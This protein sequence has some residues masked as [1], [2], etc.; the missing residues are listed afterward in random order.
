MNTEYIMQMRPWFGEEE[1][2]AICEYMDSDGFLTEF[3]LTEKFEN[4]I[5]SYT[6]SKNCIVVNNGTISMTIA[7]IALDLKA[8]DEVIVPNYTMIATPNA[9]R[10]LG[11]K[12]IF[13]DVD[14]NTLCLDW[15]KVADSLTK[16][17]K[18]VVLVSAN[19]RYPSKD[20]QEIKDFC[21]EKE[22][23][24]IE[25]A[26][27]SLGSFYPNKKHIGTEG[28]I[29]SFSFSAPKIITTGQGGALVTNNDE[30][31]AKIRRLKDF[32]RSSGGNDIHNTIGYNFKFTDL[33][34]CIGIEQMKKLNYRVELKR[35]IKNS[36][37]KHLRGVEGIKLFD[38]DLVNTTPWFI[39]SVC[40]SRDELVKFLHT[41]SIG[42]R[43]MY[44]PINEQIAYSQPGHYPVAKKIG[45][46]GLWLPSSSQL[47]YSDIL[48]VCNAIR[49]FYE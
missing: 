26:A 5:A 24:L 36:Y 27:Q 45:Q 39:D 32:G 38:Q 2:K 47:R 44:P 25:D 17:T 23:Y 21:S 29:G 1:K 7:A 35:K 49:D 3:K 31:A 42:S 19:G 22:I 13:V 43:P 15:R 4:M 11:V 14:P 10:F 28:I 40:D 12:P 16:K 6:G 41:N 30:I 46:D 37:I 33:Q 34:A 9:F 48:R 8:G 18:A 20:I